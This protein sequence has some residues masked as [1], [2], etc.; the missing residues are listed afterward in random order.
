[1][2]SAERNLHRGRNF[3]PK[4]R[5]SF[6]F[7]A[8][9]LQREMRSR[10]NTA[11]KPF[12][13]ANQTEQEVLGFDRNAAQLAGLVPGK[14]EYSSS[15]FGVPFEHPGYLR[16][17]RLCCGHGNDDHSIKHRCPETQR[18]RAPNSLS[19]LGFPS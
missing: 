18:I 17:S 11:G 1:G 13:F 12:S 9:V 6:D 19:A 15:P 7:L 5:P 16:E 3:F 8:D 10:K 4:N 14:E 2:F